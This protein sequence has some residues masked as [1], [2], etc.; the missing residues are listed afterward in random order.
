[1]TRGVRVP[2]GAATAALAL[3]SCAAAHAAEPASAEPASQPASRPAPAAAV[4]TLDF[5][6]GLYARRM[7]V[8]A[9][10]EYEKFIREAPA[11]PEVASARF[12]IA[13]SH[14][15]TR[16][17]RSA[18]EHFGRFLAEYPQDKRAS[19]A[20]FRTAT[21]RVYLGEPAEAVRDLLALSESAED[22]AIRAGA[23][24]YLGLCYESR[25]KPQKSAAVYERILAQYPESEYAAYASIALGD[26][27]F[28]AGDHERA[29]EAYRF[30]AGKEEPRAL[31]REARL[32][33]GDLYFNRGEHA[34]AAAAYRRVFEEAVE[35]D[36]LPINVA[37]DART[38][39]QR[40]LE[41]L[42]YCDY[43][44]KDAA[45]AEERY[46]AHRELVESSPGRFE[47]RYLL[48][49]LASEKGDA[50]SALAHLEAIL[51]APDA[52]SDIVDR[53]RFKKTEILAASDRG[54]GALGELDK[55]LASGSAQAAR[56][57]LEK[58]RILE[59][60]GRADEALA[61]FREVY[62]KRA[63]SEQAPR[64]LFEAATLLRKAGRPGEA[65]GLFEKFLDAHLSDA[66]ADRALLEIIQIDLDARQFESA[67]NG[68]RAFLERFPG[69]P[70]ADIAQYKRGMAEL[71]AGRHE[72]ALAAFQAV[73]TGFPSSP[74]VAEAL[75]GAASAA[76]EAGRA[77]E[78]I[79]FHE[80]VLEFH[81]DSSVYASSFRRLGYL[82]IRAQQLEKAANLAQ[83]ALEGQ[84][85][86]FQPDL[87][88]WLVQYLLDRGQFERMDKA[89]AGLERR[90]EPGTHAH[91]LAFYRAECRMGL[92]DYE[93]AVEGYTKA[94]DAKPDGEY[95]PYAWLGRGIS[96]AMLGRTAESEWDFTQ[97]LG[98]DGNPSVGVR[99]RYEIANLRLRADDWLEAAKAFMLVAIL[100]DDAKY[101]PLS[102]YKAGHCF[103]RVGRTDEARKAFA[104]LKARYPETEW[105]AKFDQQ[106]AALAAR[107]TS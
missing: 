99:A 56:A 94:I 37:G 22:P 97:A 6:N 102:L 96:R 84:E 86:P 13:D 47:I 104:E 88:L 70:F 67:A 9:I 4:P 7:Y 10:S 19:M 92:K 16:S 42:F 11:S 40:A 29:F 8:P 14:Y 21:A 63:A 66:R 71:S 98:F 25:E 53:A 27:A 89:L 34:E 72:E 61:H 58:A 39:R 45:A 30:A 31:V 64:A 49:A 3:W 15:F 5:A 62:E 74:L 1:M 48:G 83:S 75:Y 73:F 50:D 33:T 100:Y 44:T 107:R 103:L 54:D 51:A 81:P 24:F 38:L 28:R 69:S 65:R 76:E 106:L 80:R 32:K 82:Y 95:A 17:Y 79:A 93:G 101:T 85:K 23:L 105:A 87:A 60:L 90:L 59:A 46:R 68:A 52:P 2:L 36:D 12:R 77:P 57:H 35:D 43:Q 18:V 55:L 78:A 20:R 26:Q 41:G 91:E